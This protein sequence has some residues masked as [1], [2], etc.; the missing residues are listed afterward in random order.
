M[1][2]W[3]SEN[4]VNHYTTHLRMPVAPVVTV[5]NTAKRCVWVSLAPFPDFVGAKPSASFSWIR[6]GLSRGDGVRLDPHEGCLQRGESSPRRSW[7]FTLGA[8][9]CRRAVSS[10]LEQGAC[11]WVRERSRPP[12]PAKKRCSIPSL[13]SHRVVIKQGPNSPRPQPVTHSHPWRG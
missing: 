10:Q 11:S 13:P 8:R 7:R 6:D 12:D 9:S 1:S 5:D 2:P 3:R 4:T